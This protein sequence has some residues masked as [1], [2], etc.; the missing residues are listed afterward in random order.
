[1]NKLMAIN[2]FIERYRV[3]RSTVYRLFESGELSRLKIGSAT[4]IS[5]ENADTWFE[6]LKN[7]QAKQTK[8]SCQENAPE[9][10]AM[11]S[12]AYRKL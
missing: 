12:D 11:Q 2:D 8:G 4:R 7:E 9:S 6:N 1:M 5:C 10:T 3:S